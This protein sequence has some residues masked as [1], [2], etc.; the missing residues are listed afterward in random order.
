[1]S[2][3][4]DADQGTPEPVPLSPVRAPGLGRRALLGSAIAGLFG[5]AFGRFALPSGP[6]EQTSTVPTDP[7]DPPA[8]PTRA[9]APPG[10]PSRQTA[11]P[12]LVLLRPLLPFDIEYPVISFVQAV[13]GPDGTPVADAYTLA[14]GPAETAPSE[15]NVQV[16]ADEADVLT[17]AVPQAYGPIVDVHVERLDRGTPPALERM[18]HMDLA[19]PAAAT[20]GRVSVGDLWCLFPSRERWAAGPYRVS[21]RTERSSPFAV[22]FDLYA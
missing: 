7:S 19:T 10:T 16:P 4:A 3:R 20:D 12:F 17:I 1:M 21:V 2:D 13:I 14:S 9:T 11:P 5:V 15:G 8:D 18:R 22:R 6:A